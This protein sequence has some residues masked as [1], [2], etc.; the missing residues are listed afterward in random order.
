MKFIYI[1]IRRVRYISS[2]WNVGCC[3]YNFLV[4]FCCLPKRTLQHTRFSDLSQL[5]RPRQN[6]PACSLML[7][8]S[9]HR[10]HLHQWSLGEQRQR[11]CQ[12]T[13]KPEPWITWNPLN[14]KPILGS[15]F[16]AYLSMMIRQGQA[17]VLLLF[18]NL[19]TT[20]TWQMYYGILG[21][22]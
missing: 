21:D 15:F 12:Q 4:C 2:T 6:A 11:C 18:C 14:E 1:F 10:P 20:S 9:H 7:T 17:E 22:V 16:C 5:I 13:P 19:L 3:A 8:A